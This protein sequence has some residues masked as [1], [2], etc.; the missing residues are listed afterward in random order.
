MIDEDEIGDSMSSPMTT[1]EGAL[2]S[3]KNK[4]WQLRPPAPWTCHFTDHH[5]RSASDAFHAEFGAGAQQHV[6]NPH[7][8][9]PQPIYI[10]DL[11]VA[12]HQFG[13]LNV[14]TQQRS[15]DV[16]TWYLHGQRHR[17]C[18]RPRTVRLSDDFFAV[19]TSFATSLGR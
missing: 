16:L 5:T 13:D 11:E 8:I 4:L 7:D 1:F 6:P 10:Q 14:N 9:R 15:M 17:E 19:A 18:R 2:K 3:W 12:L